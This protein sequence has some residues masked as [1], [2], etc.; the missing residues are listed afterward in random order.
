R[1]RPR[2]VAL[3][4]LTESA[5]AADSRSGGRTPRRSPPAGRFRGQD[6]PG[7]RLR[8]RP[9]HVGIAPDAARVLAFDPDAEAVE[10][11]RR[12]LPAAGRDR[13]E[14]RVASGTA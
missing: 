8:G 11:A 9:A 4:R 7:A 3:R 6:R 1:P 2:G 14:Y 10:R 5:H 13:V 12:T